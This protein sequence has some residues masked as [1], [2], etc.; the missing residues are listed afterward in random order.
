MVI[1]VSSTSNVLLHLPIIYRSFI[2]TLYFE[3]CHK[4]KQLIFRSSSRFGYNY[5]FFLD[6]CFIL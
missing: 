3:C 6:I 5:L 1:T 2:L 4:R